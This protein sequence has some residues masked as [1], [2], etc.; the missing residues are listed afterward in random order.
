MIQYS[1]M[2][3]PIGR[4]GIYAVKEGIV[5]VSLPGKTHQEVLEWCSKSLGEED[6][7]QSEE[8][9]AEAK[10]QI[11][12]FLQGNRTTIDCN[13]LLVTSPFRLKT[14]ETIC[15]IPYGETR[16]YGQVAKMV[17]NPRAARAV[18]T[19]NATNPL[20]LIIPCHRVLA[21]NGIGGYGGRPDIKQWLLDLEMKSS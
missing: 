17:N 11:H 12:D 10:T 16:T 14:L 1:F 5:F 13:Y 18:G 3:T 6:S 9:C 7:I 21:S 20:P 2:N 15:T 19:A 8:W 4:L